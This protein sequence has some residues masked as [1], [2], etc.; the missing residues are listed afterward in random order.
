[1][2]D[3]LRGSLFMVLAM[4]GFAIEDAFFKAA[5][6]TGDVTAGVGTMLFGIF[7]TSFFVL[8]A[9]WIKEPL[10]SR[11]YVQGPLLIRSAFEI[12]GRLFFALS[13]AFA[14]LSTT[15]AILQA[16]PLVVTL[17]AA[18]VLKEKVGLRRWVAMSIGFAGVLL[19]LRPTPSGFDATAVFAIL[20]MIGFAGRDLMTRASP[21]EVSATQLGILG[22]L[23]VFIAGV[24]IT[25]FESAPISAPS[26]PALTMLMGT[27]LAGLVGYSALTKAMRT[28]EVSVVAPFRYSRLLIALVFAYLI[29]GE[30]P[31]ALTLIGATLIVGSGV[32]TLVRSGRK[33]RAGSAPRSGV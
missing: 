15:S 13:L 33:D 30:R 25:M 32:Y 17:G 22:F 8:Y 5:T 24:V 29:F 9:L 4:L 28:G 16:A 12:L 27:G 19:I 21:P 20:G 14:P 10:V 31:D 7:G 2:S 23:M 6:G 26:V 18:L 11:A 3:N 1:M